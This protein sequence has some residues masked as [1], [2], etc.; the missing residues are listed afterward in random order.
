MKKRSVTFRKVSFSLLFLI[1]CMLMI[2]LISEYEPTHMTILPTPEEERDP[3][4]DDLFFDIE[5]DEFYE[6]DDG[7]ENDMSFLEL[8]LHQDASNLYL[9]NLYLE[10][11][12]GELKDEVESWLEDTYRY[13]IPVQNILYTKKL[14]QRADLCEPA[15]YEEVKEYTQILKKQNYTFQ[16]Y[17]DEQLQVLRQKQA[18]LQLALS[19]MVEKSDAASIDLVQRTFLDYERY[20]MDTYGEGR[21]T[22]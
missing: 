20:Y 15:W 7:K 13:H 2:I 9:Q 6:E 1:Q 17:K 8:M 5:E 3:D 4:Q 10:T 16:L 18:Q 14:F 11:S 19:E 12:Y 22:S 21:W